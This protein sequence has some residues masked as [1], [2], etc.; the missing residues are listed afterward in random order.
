MFLLLQSYEYIIIKQKVFNTSCNSYKYIK[1]LDIN[2]CLSDYNIFS[3]KRIDS[4][5]YKYKYYL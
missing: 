2:V 5:N 1:C 3:E 4:Y